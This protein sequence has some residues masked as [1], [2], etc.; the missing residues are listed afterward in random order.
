MATIRKAH[1]VWSGDLKSGKGEVTFDSSGIGS[2][3]VTW[4]ARSEESGGKTSPEELIAAAHSSCFSMALSNELGKK[5]HTAEQIH[6]TAEVDFVP[7][8]G[9]TT[10]N[11]TVSAK[12]PGLAADEFNEIAQAAGKGCPVSQALKGITINVNASLE[13]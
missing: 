1:T 8:T 12:V 2:H 6:T 13:S 10:S 3:A 5:G 9:I 4:K 11:I 7:G